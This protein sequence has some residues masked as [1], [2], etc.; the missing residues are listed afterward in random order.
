MLAYAIPGDTRDDYLYMAESIAIDCM[1]RFYWAIVVVHG[2]KYPR[3]SNA[4][5][6]TRILE[7]NA[8]RGFSGML[9]SI[10]CMHWAW[11][12]CPF[13]HQD[14]YKGHK[15]SCS[16]VLEVVAALDMWIWH[17]FFG[18]SGSHNDI[19]V[20]QYSNVFGSLVEGR[21]PPVQFEIN[22]HQYDKGYYLAGGIY[23]RWSTFMKTISNPVP[24]ENKAWF[25]TQKEVCRKDVERAFG[26]LQ[27]RFSIVRYLAL[28]WSKYQIWEVMIV[29]AILYNMIIESEHETL[30]FDT[31]PYYR[32]GPLTD[33][34]HQVPHVFA[35]FLARRQEVRDINT[36]SQLQDDMMEHLWRLKGAR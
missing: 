28:T 3:T 7:Q 19:N 32:Q 8:A 29:C 2:K 5:D 35:S 30:V 6:T 15:G 24:R 21:A 14:M 31:E 23:R 17:A 34:D 4:E 25:A 36:H 10:D 11:K 13:A 22:G 26:A 33:I 16:V 27:A 12:N 18:M 20:L 9:G 1:Y